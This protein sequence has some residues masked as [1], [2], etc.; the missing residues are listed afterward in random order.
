MRFKRTFI[1]TSS[2]STQNLLL[3]VCLFWLLAYRLCVRL[4]CR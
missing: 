1:I 2:Y 4:S 3:F